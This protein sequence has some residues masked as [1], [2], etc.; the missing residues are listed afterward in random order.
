MYTFSNIPSVYLAGFGGGE[1]GRRE[2]EKKE[3]RR[4]WRRKKEEEGWEERLFLPLYSRQQLLLQTSLFLNHSCGM[5]MFPPPIACMCIQIPFPLAWG[6]GGF[7]SCGNVY[8][9]ICMHICLPVRRGVAVCSVFFIFPFGLDHPV[10][11]PFWAWW[12]LC[13]FQQLSDRRRPSINYVYVLRYFI[14][15]EML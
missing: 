10:I 11:V 15:C 8:I 3:G 9:Y 14:V 5:G 12:Q 7:S 1:G 2:E 13:G 6:G 4:W